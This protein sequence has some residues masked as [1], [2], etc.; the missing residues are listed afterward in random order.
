MPDITRTPYFL[1]A[2]HYCKNVIVW[3][4]QEECPYC[5]RSW[6]KLKKASTR[7]VNEIVESEDND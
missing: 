1:I 6:L 2:G 4:D 3:T 7:M 5:D